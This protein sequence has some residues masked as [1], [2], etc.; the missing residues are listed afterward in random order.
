[1]MP[2]MNAD[3][4]IQTQ[5]ALSVLLRTNS[6]NVILVCQAEDTRQ[7]LE[8]VRF[9]QLYNRHYHLYLTTSFTHPYNHSVIITIII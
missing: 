5:R 1:M 8:M 2:E 9:S 6:R 4:E 7:L 3:D